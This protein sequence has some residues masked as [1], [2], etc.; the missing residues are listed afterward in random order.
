MSEKEQIYGALLAVMKEVHPI[1]KDQSG[2]G[3]QYKFRGIEQV[4]NALHELHSKHGILIRSEIMDY[5]REERQ[6][7]KGTL[8]LTTLARIRWY[9]VA[10]DGSEM[11]SETIGEGM[12]YSGD[13]S[14]NKAMSMALKYSLLQLYLIPTEETAHD[15]TE[16]RVI[17][18]V[19]AGDPKNSA[20]DPFAIEC[21]IRDIGGDKS[22]PKLAEAWN[23]L[24]PIEQSNREVAGIFKTFQNEINEARKDATKDG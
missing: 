9:F 20:V 16:G 19:L 21:M 24:T 17:E 4:Y 3:I 22:K 14:A 7:N 5:K 11:W 23:S 13:K 10:S 12:D 8:I 15:N 2:T 6:N 18:N 1:K